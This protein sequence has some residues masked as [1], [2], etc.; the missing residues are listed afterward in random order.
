VYSQK[1]NT[2]KVYL[3]C[4]GE[5]MCKLTHFLAIMGESARFVPEGQKEMQFG[6]HL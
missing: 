6:L 3:D 4:A 5:Y 1:E 2:L